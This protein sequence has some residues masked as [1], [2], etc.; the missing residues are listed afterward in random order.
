MSIIQTFVSL[1]VIFLGFWFF[2]KVAYRG[3]AGS[4]RI[5]NFFL[6]GRNIG[7]PLFE[8]TTWGTGFA[9]GNGIFYF[10]WLGYTWG[11]SAIWVQVPYCLGFVGLAVILP[12]IV[13]QTEKYTLHGFLGS[14]FGRK[15]RFM[16]SVA[17][18][19]GFL[20]N[21]GFEIVFA[22]TVLSG[23]FGS[24]HLD[25]AITLVMAIFVAAYCNIGGYRANAQTDRWQN[26]FGVG[27][28]LALVFLF[29]LTAAKWNVSSEAIYL[30]TILNSLFDF[31]KTSLPF[32]LGLFTLSFLYPFVDMTNWQNVAA[33]SLLPPEPGEQRKRIRDMRIALLKASAWVFFFPGVFGVI[34][35]YLMQG[36][37]SLEQS[38]ILTKLIAGL[39]PG[40]TLAYGLVYAIILG[41]LMVGLLGTT[42]ST[43]DSWLI[44]S[45]QTLSWDVIDFKLLDKAKFDV[46]RIPDS[47]H[48]RIT[49]RSRNILFLLAPIASV[50]FYVSYKGIGERIIE[51]Q[52]VIYGAVISL[53]PLL[54]SSLY[55]LRD[56]DKMVYQ[57]NRILLWS[58]FLSIAIGYL[59][60]IGVFILSFII[61]G[62]DVYTWAPIASL[63][64]A[65]TSLVVGITFANI[66]RKREDPGH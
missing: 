48:E 42:L 15:T 27:A 28:L 33:N 19:T 21:I 45:S 63:A 43:V 59:S 18:M 12:K 65:L 9:L 50:I 51:F 60:A 44:A 34:L 49:T 39:I 23:L 40:G 17:S 52:F 31:S 1:A 7:I 35:G 61:E 30:P 46:T 8:H 13:V 5:E 2:I 36:V 25:L 66:R 64:A 32:V 54:I 41:V 38:E 56:E 11:L 58:A 3:Q 57:K 62:L 22:A 47:V 4:S 26:W 20:L 55:L 53:F 29:L 24:K 6:A 10:I 37:P 16:A 14:F